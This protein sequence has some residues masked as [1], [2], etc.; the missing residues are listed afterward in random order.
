ME[1]VDSDCFLHSLKMVA[2]AQ[3]VKSDLKIPFK[4]GLTHDLIIFPW[5]YPFSLEFFIPIFSD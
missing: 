4:L 5:I 3:R 1:P 2:L